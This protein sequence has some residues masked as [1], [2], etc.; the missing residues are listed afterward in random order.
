M[1]EKKRGVG[2]GEERKKRVGEKR[3]RERESQPYRSST[4]PKSDA[5]I[6]KIVGVKHYCMCIPV[7]F[8]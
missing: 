6:Q 4:K 7:I 8:L 3:E 2:G 5:D 1:R